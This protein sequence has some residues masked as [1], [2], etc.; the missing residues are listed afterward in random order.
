MTRI[1]IVDDNSQNL[2]LLETVLNGAGY[3]VGSPPATAPRRWT[4]PGSAR[5]TW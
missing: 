4:W 2:Y 3:E 1:L 5:R